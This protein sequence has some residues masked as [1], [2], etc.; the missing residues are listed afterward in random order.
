MAA[1]PRGSCFFA[2][3]A[4]DAFA[5]PFVEAAFEPEAS[6]ALAGA[7]WPAV[8]DALA[9]PDAPFE[10][11]AA[12]FGVAPAFGAVSPAASAFAGFFAIGR[13][14]EVITASSPAS[15][16]ALFFALRAAA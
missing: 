1:M 7:F 9:F 11:L 5:G 15:A 4:A 13:A 16:A 8:F 6:F 14:L 2:F 3:L 12:D 10:L